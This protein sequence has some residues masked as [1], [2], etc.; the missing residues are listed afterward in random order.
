MK[1]LFYYLGPLLLTIATALV[2]YNLLQGFDGPGYALLG[3]GNWSIEMSFVVF[4]VAQIL[5]F[6]VFY[7]FF[8]TIGYLI[9]LPGRLKTKGRNVKFNR[10]QEALIAGL[11]DSAEGNWERAENVPDTMRFRKQGSYP[12]LFLGPF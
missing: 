9:R 4:V 8:R 1:K 11:V 7:V 2:V 6:Y 5:T 10:S 3:I 12:A